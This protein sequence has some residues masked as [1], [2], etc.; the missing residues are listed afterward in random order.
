[1]YPFPYSQ[2]YGL[3]FRLHLT[4]DIEWINPPV[5][6]LK[7]NRCLGEVPSELITKA[8]LRRS[9]SGIPRKLSLF[10]TLRLQHCGFFGLTGSLLLLEFSLVAVSRSYIWLWYMGFSL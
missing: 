2:S 1:M 9:E 6:S 8:I 5:F 7:K 10:F 4:V 3:G